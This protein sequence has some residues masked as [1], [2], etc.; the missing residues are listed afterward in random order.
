MKNMKAQLTNIKVYMTKDYESFNKVAGNRNL[1]KSHL[2]KLEKSMKENPLISPIC[3]NEKFEIIDGQNRK[4]VCSKLD[5]PVYFYVIPDYGIKEVQIFN[6]N[7]SN[8][9]KSD[10]LEMHCQAGL[11][12]YLKFRNFMR[13]YPYFSIQTCMLLLTLNN[14]PGART[15]K[16]AASE[17]NKYGAWNAKLFENG[18]LQ[19]PDFALSCAIAEKIKNF[20]P[21]TKEWNKNRFIAAFMGVLTFD[22]YNHDEMIKKMENNHL[23]INICP[24]T[25]KYREAIEEVYNYKRSANNKVSFK[26]PAGRILS[27]YLL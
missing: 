23:T 9:Q 12:E 24:T 2:F 16:E 25:L 15:N 7:I 6:T 5:L 4:E 26:Y 8:W 13:K 21:Y 10:Y 27:K 14:A 22:Y 18:E 17:T 1:K 20:Q 3:C 11:P 19:I